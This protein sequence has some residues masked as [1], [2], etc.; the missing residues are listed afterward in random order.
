MDRRRQL[1]EGKVT[2][3]DD[4]DSFSCYKPQFSIG[5]LGD[6]RSIGASR[7][8]RILT[9]SAASQTV[10]SILRFG[11][12]IH[13]SSSLRR[14][15]HQAAGRVQPERT[16][17]VLHRPVN[18]VARQTIPCCERSDAAVFKPAKAALLGCR[19]TASHPDRVGDR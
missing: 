19:P 17:V 5:G 7:T 18:R 3:I 15:A 10:V 2:G 12:A 8:E 9:P 4:L 11:S 14:Y 1:V 6:A 16:I 13:A